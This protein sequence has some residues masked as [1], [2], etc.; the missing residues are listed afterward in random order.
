MALVPPKAFAMDESE[1]PIQELAE[2]AIHD[3][4][5]HYNERCMPFVWTA[6]ADVILDK[7]SR[8]CERTSETR[9]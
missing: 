9:H 5:A 2:A 7:V 1:G 3:Y 8:F 6:T 4:L